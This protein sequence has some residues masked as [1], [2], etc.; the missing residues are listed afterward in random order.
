MPTLP[1]HLPAPAPWH[2]DAT[3]HAAAAWAQGRGGGAC[4][5]LHLG[6]EAL[7]LAWGGDGPQPAHQA[8][9]PL[10][11]RALA[12]R[13]FPGEQPTPQA[14]EAAIEAVENQV[15]PWQ[16]RLPPGARLVTGD[17]AIAELAAWAGLPSDGHAVQLGTEALEPLFDRWVA[18]ALGRP[19]SQD[20]LPTTGRFSAA[21][22]V[23]RECLHHLGVGAITV[24]PAPPSPVS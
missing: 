22:L 19:A 6:E 15:M 10:G 18:R 11:L 1:P 16:R 4:V 7:A 12:Q 3:R 17:T 2:Q 5:A 9:L 8:L 21:L 13:Y 14:I 20:P 23:L 24:Y